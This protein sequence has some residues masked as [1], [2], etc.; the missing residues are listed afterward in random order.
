[1]S[2]LN[3]LVKATVAGGIVIGSAVAYARLSD[4]Q[5]ASINNSVSRAR[6]K[7]AD[8]IAPNDGAYTLP[9]E[10]EAELEALLN[11]EEIRR[12]PDDTV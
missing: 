5:K 1:M 6:R 11:N 8:L 4:E 3:N 12:G 10:V 7:L 2:V 9:K